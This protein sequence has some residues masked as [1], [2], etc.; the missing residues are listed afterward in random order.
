MIPRAG[1]P[2]EAITQ[3]PREP[4]AQPSLGKR[5]PPNSHSVP[6]SYPTYPLP[7]PTI[8]SS[9]S[10]VFQRSVP[11]LTDPHV[12]SF[13]FPVPEIVSMR[14]DDLWGI[15]V[16]LSSSG[17]VFQLPTFNARDD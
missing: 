2:A 5:L 6:P 1:H 16:A 14:R 8:L 9:T 13:F 17:T 12:L 10:Y 4:S 3:A 11:S 15:I 7:L